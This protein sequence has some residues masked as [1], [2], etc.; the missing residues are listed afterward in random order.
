VISTADKGTMY[1]LRNLINRSAVPLDP[2][3]N[4]KAAED[5]LLLL[6]HAHVIE[7]QNTISSAIHYES[8]MSIAKAIVNNYVLLSPIGDKSKKMQNNP[9]QVHLYAKELLTF[10]LIWYGFHD[11]IKHSDGVRIYRYWKVLLV[12]FKSTDRRNYG[13]EAVNLLL[14]QYLLSP[15]KAAQLKW[16]RCINTTGEVGGNI[17]C[18]L[19]IEHLN[20]RLK[21]I[22]RNLGS[23]I[24]PKSIVR[25]GQT[26]GT[27]HRVCQVFEYETIGKLNNTH[28]PHPSFRKDLNLVLKVLHEE[29]VFTPLKERCHNTFKSKLKNGLFQ[30]CDRGKMIKKIQDSLDQLLHT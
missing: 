27:V 23:N 3:D 19:H 25:A 21:G 12:I 9:D 22:L 2:Q 24:N 6:L 20:R 18:D 15:R 4:T 16:S 30:G 11:S 10:S 5:F 28:H 8:V 13:K 1:Q 29:S 26:V 17:P 7:A 14:Q